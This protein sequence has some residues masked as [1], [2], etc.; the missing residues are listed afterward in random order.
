MPISSETKAKLTPSHYRQGVDADQVIASLSGTTL[1]PAQKDLLHYML[2]HKNQYH[3]VHHLG[4]TLCPS[5]FPHPESY[6]T[7]QDQ[8]DVDMRDNLKTSISAIRKVL[9]GTSLEIR[10]ITIPGD[11]HVKAYGLF[12]CHQADCS[13]NYIATT[14]FNSF[15]QDYNK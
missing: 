4:A 14:N 12:D 15:N 7:G 11:R 6:V 5:A 13:E 3:R 10:R 9:K 1:R 2:R 8:L